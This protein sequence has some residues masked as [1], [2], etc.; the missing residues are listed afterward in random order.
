[1]QGPTVQFVL[2]GPESSLGLGQL[3]NLPL[4]RSYRGQ[5][6]RTF[7]IKRVCCSPPPPNI[8]EP[9]KLIMALV[10]PL[11]NPFCQEFISIPHFSHRYYHLHLCWLVLE[12]CLPFSLNQISSLYRRDGWLIQGWALK[13]FYSKLDPVKLVGWISLLLKKKKVGGGRNAGWRLWSNKSILLSRFCAASGS[14]KCIKIQMER[15]SLPC[16]SSL[17]LRSQRQGTWKLKANPSQLPTVFRF[18]PMLHFS[19]GAAMS[20][21]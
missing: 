17:S 10:K 14:L 1:M 20:E 9:Q 18:V 13:S 2:Q 12:F 21:T 5:K 15:S 19:A 8:L 11:K 6:C 16:L 7:Q 4:S 3:A